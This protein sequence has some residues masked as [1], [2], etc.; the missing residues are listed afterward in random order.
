MADEY[1]SRN[2]V[3]ERLEEKKSSICPIEPWE[4]ERYRDICDAIDSD[5]DTVKNV[6]SVNVV[7]RD[8][9]DRI[10]W[11]NDIMRKQLADIGKS[12]GE[13]M[14]DV[15]KVVHG[16]WEWNDHNGYY[17]CSECNA[18]SPREDQEGE[19]CDTP[20]YCHRCGAKMD[21]E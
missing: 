2:A 15:Q 4:Y 5:I 19:Y 7:T 1:I 11:E 20:M 10:L 6:Q 17:Y 8:C 21:L 18:A 13:K 9:Y 12:F 16:K 3:I 14:D